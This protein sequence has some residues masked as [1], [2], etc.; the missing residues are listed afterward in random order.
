MRRAR[1]GGGVKCEMSP[2]GSRC[3]YVY[4][5]EGGGYVVRW[6]R[7]MGCL[8]FYSPIPLLR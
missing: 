6:G 8:G 7:V 3:I 4:G 5:V 1:C 2:V